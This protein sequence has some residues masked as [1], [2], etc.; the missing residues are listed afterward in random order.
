MPSGPS[1]NSI[2]RTNAHLPLSVIS[3]RVLRSV[4]VRA[5]SSGELSVISTSSTYTSTSTQ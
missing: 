3:K 5:I 1:T 2:P 4:F